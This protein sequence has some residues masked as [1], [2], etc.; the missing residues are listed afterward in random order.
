MY[1][2]S[3]ILKHAEYSRDPGI[4]PW[5][6]EYSHEVRNLLLRGLGLLTIT[7]PEDIEALPIGSVIADATGRAW[8]RETPY[9]WIGSSRIR[10]GQ[11]IHQAEKIKFFIRY[12][13]APAPWLAA[14][15]RTKETVK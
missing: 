10:T 6:R 1:V 5:S 14:P 7:D 4:D 12:V 13:H 9:I 2:R 3:L 15:S 11:L 8:I